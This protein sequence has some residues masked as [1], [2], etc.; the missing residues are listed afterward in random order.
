MSF[1]KE[2]E[3]RLRFAIP[4]RRRIHH[5]RE[6]Q[7]NITWALDS[8]TARLGLLEQRLE[9]FGYGP[10]QIR[11]TQLER[12]LEEHRR[13]VADLIDRQSETDRAL[14]AYLVLEFINSM[15]ADE[16]TRVP[17]AIYSCLPPMRSGI[18]D[19]TWDAIRDF[20][21]PFHVFASLPHFSDFVKLQ[22]RLARRDQRVFP[23]ASAADI[24]K[25]CDYGVHL[26]VLGNS[27]HHIQSVEEMERV[28][29]AGD[30]IVAH[31]HEPQMTQ[32]W[33]DYHGNDQEALK[34]FYALYYPEHASALR[35]SRGVEDIVKIPC[36]G[37]RPFAERFGVTKMIFNSENARNLA[38]GDL[39]EG[40]S[41]ELELLF[42]PIF[43][44]R[45]KP[46][47][48]LPEKPLVVG[49]FG[50]PDIK[51]GCDTLIQACEIISLSRPVKLV[52]CGWYA[53]AIIAR[54]CPEPKPFVT[55][56]D[57]P[58]DRD[59]I[60]TMDDVHLAVQLRPRDAG[61]SSAALHALLAQGKSTIVTATGSFT[62]YGD[63]VVTV[64]VDVTAEALAEIIIANANVDRTAAIKNTLKRYS[65]DL[66]H[67]RLR[68]ILDLP[69]NESGTAH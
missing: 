41:V 68:E 30:R 33:S 13:L 65:V 60:A 36:L 16:I 23:V 19:A 18:A 49:H 6:S 15:S 22:R 58:D 56:V 26:F 64:P 39:R 5:V 4:S 63:A 61:E 21:G 24:R 57:S 27:L 25:R 35:A 62:D 8:V 66:F 44:P 48:P 38:R 50:I 3:R 11:L 67:K 28:S 45:T 1:L 47:R 12:T 20:P 42:L 14:A 55:V 52:F 46:P 2:L 7:K 51:K 29:S 17:L 59:F 10:D 31:F 43:D 34:S 37:L 40:R 54:L 32:F 9:E 53:K 69:D